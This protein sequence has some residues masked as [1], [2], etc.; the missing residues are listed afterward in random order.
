[1]PTEAFHH[2]SRAHFTIAIICPLPLEAE[3]AIP[4]FDTVYDRTVYE[5]YGPVRNDP[6]H[7]TLGRIGCYNVVLAHMGG[8]GKAESSSVA[9]NIK[10]SYPGIELAL[11]IGIC[12]GVPYRTDVGPTQRRR[13]VFLGDVIIS[14]AIIQYDLGKRLPHRF[15]RKNTLESNL[16]RASLQIRS[17]MTCLESR[18]GDLSKDQQGH[19]Q[20]IQGSKDVPYPGIKSDILFKAEYKHRVRCL[21]MSDAS[22]DQSVVD[23]RRVDSDGT[24][25]IHI[26]RLASGD[27]VMC[28]AKDRDKI[29]KREE[30]LG[31]EMEGAGV[32]DNIPCILIKGVSDYADS[33]K[34]DTWQYFAAASAVACMRALLDQNPIPNVTSSAGLAQD[35]IASQL[36]PRKRP[37]ETSEDSSNERE[38]ACLDLL[39][40]PQ[41][42][43]RLDEIMDPLN[44]TC[45]WVLERPEYKTWMSGEDLKSHGGFFWIKGKPGA[46]K[47]TLMKHLLP[48]WKR[49][50]HLLFLF[51]CPRG[52]LREVHCGLKHQLLSL[53]RLLNNRYV[54]FFIDALDECDQAEMEDMIP[55]LEHLGH[56]LNA[57]D[58]H[59]RICL[60]SRHYPQLNIE[61]G[62]EWVLEYQQE[63]QGDMRK[64]VETKLKGGKSKM[65]QEIRKEVCARAS[66][67]FLWVILV[68][69]S[70]NDAFAKGKIHAVRQRLD[71]IP[72]GLDELF[73]D[74]L[75]RDTEEIDDLIFCLRLILFAQRPLS[76]DEFYFGV[77]F[78]KNGL[79]KREG[80]WHID[81]HIENFILNV[82]KGLAEITRT[83]ARIVHFIHESVRD[84]LL[85]RD[86]F[87]R[88]QAGSS[89]N[90]IG[91][92]HNE[93][94]KIC[95]RYIC[96]YKLV[97][98][99]GVP[100]RY[101]W[102]RSAKSWYLNSEH[103][104]LNYA[105]H[106]LLPH[107]NAAEAGGISQAAFLQKFS[108]SFQ[109][110]KDIRNALEQCLIRH[111]GPEVTALYVLAELNLD[112]L[113]RLELLRTPQM[114]K[115]MG[116]YHS[117]MG[118][119]VYLGNT[120]AIR[121]LLGCNTSSDASVDN[122]LLEAGVIDRMKQY[123]VNSKR[124]KMKRGSMALY[125]VEYAIKRGH[126]AI[127]KL[128]YLTGKIDL[129]HKLNCRSLP[130][131]CA[132]KCSK[133]EIVEFLLSCDR[134]TIASPT[135]ALRIAIIRGIRDIC[136]ALLSSPYSLRWLDSYGGVAIQWAVI[137]NNGSTMRHLLELGC[138]VTLRD[139]DG[140]D[141]LSHAAEQG[142]IEMMKILIESGVVD[143]DGKDSQGRTALSWAA[144]PHKT[145][146]YRSP[147]PNICWDQLQKEVMYVLLSTG[148]V[149]VNS[150]DKHQWTPLLWAVQR[151]K[152]VAVDILLEA[153]ETE[154]DCRSVTGKT[155]LTVAAMCG[156]EAMLCKLLQS[157]RVDVNSQDIFGRTPL[158]WAVY[159]CDASIPDSFGHPAWWW[160]QAWRIDTPAAVEWIKEEDKKV[161]QLLIDHLSKKNKSNDNAV[162]PLDRETLEREIQVVAASYT[163]YDY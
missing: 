139:R 149:D 17:F 48:N 36:N 45:T 69:R 134:V 162:L 109:D 72:D 87:S 158:S 23:R 104:F 92:A 35:I 117:P 111:Y 151:N 146:L 101:E 100:R 113:I 38:K 47:S 44:T 105:I 29:S 70:L 110:F 90:T 135:N 124:I 93:L 88:L 5:K 4:L 34:N 26:G 86:G 153:S 9:S 46:G 52:G 103:P 58:V 99:N 14:S 76:K 116:R 125:L 39:T 60:A 130:L 78:T 1:M 143:I 145:M 75:T 112:H 150:R 24:P 127:L 79:I 51:P 7:Y 82:S 107:S 33:H 142:K 74:M 122:S 108:L 2:L 56:S 18:H 152:P 30:V 8:C 80:E 157:G 120:L 63:H 96:E 6:N 156:H 140:R 102:L 42:E 129:N 155:P 123:V 40:F 137:G 97:A 148:R 131:I 50:N 161:M 91:N 121:A 118:A 95:F 27:T 115:Q 21:C 53:I 141:A 71:E 126:V 68:V 159:P 10:Q 65:L 32:W 16:G 13:D 31:F 81:P 22:G 84:F 73:T 61:R 3:V 144:G 89:A 106:S 11:L 43:Y 128:L 94:A 20:T 37:A 154:I 98:A 64:Y 160:A 114:W 66:G 15:V 136:S 49:H 132:I 28:S 25:Y 119:A 138:D 54:F 41:A 83:K 77:M 85:R 133:A 163:P 59:L 57:C 55:F 67:V 147:D 12:G 19:L 62:I